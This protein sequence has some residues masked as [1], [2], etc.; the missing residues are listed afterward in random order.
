MILVIIFTFASCP[1]S[2]LKFKQENLHMLLRENLDFITMLPL[3]MVSNGI[4]SIARLS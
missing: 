3:K 1:L 2:S 4:H